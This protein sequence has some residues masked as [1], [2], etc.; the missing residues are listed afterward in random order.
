MASSINNMVLAKTI[1]T[2]N[3]IMIRPKKK[4]IKQIKKIITIRIVFRKMII[5]KRMLMTARN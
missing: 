5:K 3:K 4:P 1:K 2:K